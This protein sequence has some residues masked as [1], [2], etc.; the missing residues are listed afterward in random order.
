MSPQKS[1]LLITLG[2]IF[3]ATAPEVNAQKMYWTTGTFESI[4][5][6]N[7]DGSDVEIVIPG[8]DPDYPR[9]MALDLGAGQMYWTDSGNDKIRRAGFDGSNSQDLVSGV[10]ALGI[11]LDL[12]HSKM[13]WTESGPNKIRRADLDGTNIEDLV[14]TE[15]SAQGIALDPDGGKMY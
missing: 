2:L 15:E 8:T 14:T 11:A 1:I 13:Y 9:G 12:S 3:T 5:R 6:A 10:N 7:L 4:E